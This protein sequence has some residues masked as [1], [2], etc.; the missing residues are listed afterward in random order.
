MVDVR[1]VDVREPVAEVGGEAA[2]VVA[3]DGSVTRV[4][5]NVPVPAPCRQR[6][7]GVDRE[8]PTA[9]GG[10]NH[11]ASRTNTYICASLVTHTIDHQ[12]RR[13]LISERKY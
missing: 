1:Q 3:C 10:V 9:T 7:T 12:S 4:E 13:Q 11:R 6:L 2:D 8:R 5:H